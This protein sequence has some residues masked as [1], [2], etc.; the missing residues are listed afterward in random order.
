MDVDPVYDNF[1]TMPNGFR[2]FV[3]NEAR[4]IGLTGYVQR[5][6]THHVEVQIEGIEHEFFAFNRIMERLKRDRIIGSVKFI[7]FTTPIMFRSFSEISILRDASATC[8]K[9][10]RSPDGYE[11]TSAHSSADREVL[12][13]SGDRE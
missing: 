12:Y 1:S 3:A 6:R 13:G 10:P 4:G 9:G 8:K 5:L 7:Q 2:S 11:A